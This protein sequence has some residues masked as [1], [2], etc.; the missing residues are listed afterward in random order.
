MYQDIERLKAAGYKVEQ[1]SPWH[2]HVKGPVTLNIWP[3]KR[4]WM[5]EYGSGAS[6]YTDIL[7]TVR[8]VI[9]EP[10]KRHKRNPRWLLDQIIAQYEAGR[11]DADREAE[12]I[13]REG[14]TALR[15]RLST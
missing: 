11:T 3:T 9:G 8:E 13:W 14:I 2:F 1:K 12:R 15:L 6:F 4:K 5:I 10:R 7:E